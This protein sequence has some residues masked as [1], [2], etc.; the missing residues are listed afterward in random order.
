MG[1]QFE[2]LDC[3]QT[4]LGELILR[5][6]RV[7]SLPGTVVYEVKLDG[8]FLMSSLVNEAERALARIA[9]YDRAEGPCDVLVGGLGLGHTVAAAL[10][11]P[12]VRSVTVIEY[13]RPVID[14][15]RAGLGPLGQRLTGDPRC[16]IVHADFFD[17]VRTGGTAAVDEE[18]PRA[19]DAILVD[20]DHSP[21]CW[22]HADHAS[23]YSSA[24]LR[25]SRK[26]LRPQGIFALWSAD[27]PDTTFTARLAEIFTDVEAHEIRF[28]NPLLNRRDSNTIFIARA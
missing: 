25:S 2:E 16:R 10:E 9:L 8:R 14:W 3:Q 22:L 15:H 18:L 6:R 19:Y 17:F 24:G 12:V 4:P 27:P 13:L 7:V 11:F 1:K 28:R 5:R 21:R 23:F 26:L 20:I